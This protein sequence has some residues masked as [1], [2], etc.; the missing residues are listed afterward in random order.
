MRGTVIRRWEVIPCWQGN[1]VALGRQELVTNLHT[2]WF[3]RGTD[4]LQEADPTLISFEYKRGIMIAL[5][6]MKHRQGRYDL[7]AL[8]SLL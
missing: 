6:S 3:F 5:R 4:N 2:A 7:A 1:V 8:L